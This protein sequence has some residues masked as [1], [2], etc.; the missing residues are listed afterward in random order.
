[1]TLIEHTLQHIALF[2]QDDEQSGRLKRAIGSS[3]RSQLR[4]FWSALLGYVGFG[5]LL[6]NDSC[7]AG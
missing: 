4:S 5:I 6:T 2:N 3:V 1:M 7:C